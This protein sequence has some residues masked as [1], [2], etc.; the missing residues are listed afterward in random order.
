MNT[1]YTLNPDF[2]VTHF[3]RHHW[4]RTPLVIRQAIPDFSD[5]V[6]EH[7]LAGLA[8]DSE[9]DA[10]IVAKQGDQWQVTEG[11]F[12]D[13]SEVCQG[14]W[15]LLVQGVDRYHDDVLTLRDCFRFIPN[16]RIEDVMVSFSV[17]DAGVGPHLDQYDVFIIQGKGQRRWQVGQAGEYSEHFP[18]PRLRQIGSPITP[19]IDEVLEPGDMIYIPPGF[20][21]NGV[22]LSPCLNYSVGFRAPSQRELLSGFADYVLDNEGFERR[23]QDPDVAPR[24]ASSEIKQ[25]E[26][27]AFRQMLLQMVD[28]DHFD[29]F[30]QQFLSKPFDDQAVSLLSEQAWRE[31]D[32]LE[33]LHQS[34]GFYR[35]ADVRTVFHPSNE[36]RHSEHYYLFINEQRFA[37]PRQ[38][39]PEI[40]DFIE[41]A[42]WQPDPKLTYA[43]C[44]FFVRFVATLVNSGYW[45]PE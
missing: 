38:H 37:I 30:V 34:K 22:A 44:L 3:V 32:V 2:D 21:H 1:N 27:D 28:S 20:P 35:G 29:Q 13:F 8:Q 11:P 40:Q 9:V 26:I 16:W 6:D 45:F 24:G 17:A 23:Y 43:N 12:D 18:H 4:Q 41:Q 15:S 36:N 42:F 33:Y 10:R 31:Q 39:W 5:P 14:A 25:Q 7:E 19:V